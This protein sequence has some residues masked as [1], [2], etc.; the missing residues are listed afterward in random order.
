MFQL[1]HFSTVQLDSKL[2]DLLQKEITIEVCIL[3]QVQY[4][5]ELVN[6]L[7]KLAAFC[8][9]LEFYV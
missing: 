5:Y 7:R 3:V 8:F 6:R 2:P 1:C 4:I 9:S